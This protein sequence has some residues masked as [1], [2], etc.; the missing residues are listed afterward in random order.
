MGAGLGILSDIVAAERRRLG[1]E[2][3]GPGPFERALRGAAL[4]VIAEFKRASPSLGPFAADADPA[5]RLGAYVRGGAA[6]F[7]VLAEPARFGGRPGDFEVARRFGRPIL[8]KGFVCT[9]GHLR[10]ALVL[11]AQAVL[12]IA[13]VLG[14]ELPAYA[15]A[16]RALGL[17]PLAE[18]HA[19]DEIPAVQASGARLVGWNVRDLSDFSEGPAD[20]GPL[21]AAFP[22]AVLIRES[23]LKD[24]AAIRAA[25]AS[26]WDA[27]LAGEAL[28]RAPDPAALLAEARP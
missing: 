26:G 14:D 16:A 17:E 19:A 12:L 25:L 20:P 22:E 24:A 21:R 27:V 6:C 2:P 11:G 8:Y 4:P 18:I 3:E 28:M 7:S 1:A 5:E 9:P 15:F 13:R 23:G 10:E